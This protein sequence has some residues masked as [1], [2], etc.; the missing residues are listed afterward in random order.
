MCMR[1]QFLPISSSSISR[2]AQTTP[3]WRNQFPAQ[4]FFYF[5]GPPLTINLSV[6]A[7]FSFSSNKS[8]H[9]DTVCQVS[10]QQIFFFPRKFH[11]KRLP[12]S[13]LRSPVLE[14]GLQGL[15]DRVPLL[16]GQQ[17]L[18][19]LAEGTTVDLDARR[20]DLCHP[21]QRAESRRSGRWMISFFRMQV[22]VDKTSLM[23]AR[24][25]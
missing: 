16:D 11:I 6:S 15:A 8:T 25:L 10:R 2:R 20:K 23:F 17:V 7:S 12:P 1:V 19:L 9:S 24:H 22:D 13:V 4:L 5:T 18:Q 3:I 21:L 14:E